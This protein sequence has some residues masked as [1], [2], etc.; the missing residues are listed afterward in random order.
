MANEK[1]S[2]EEIRSKPS[3]VK[4]RAFIGGACILAALVVALGVPLAEQMTSG[5]V[6]VLE[7]ND[8]IIQGTQITSKNMSSLL[9]AVKV[10][11]DSVPAGAILSSQASLVVGKYVAYTMLKNDALTSE[12][13]SAQDSIYDLKDGHMLFSVAIKSFADGVSGKLQ[14]GDIVTV[15]TPS[16]QSNSATTKSASIIPAESPKELQFLKVVAVS[17]SSG[18]D[19]DAKA[20]QSS[21]SSDSSLPASVTL[22]VTA[23]QAEVLT[24]LDNSNIHFGLVNRGNETLANQLLTEQDAVLKS[25]TGGAKK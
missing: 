21:G 17:T 10:S 24:A 25:E 8:E 15:F 4:S 13:L 3:V 20:I 6:T 9:T 12:K 1:K 18:K 16:Q 14:P 2:T 7:A 22:E 11:K 5:K 19:A 23:K